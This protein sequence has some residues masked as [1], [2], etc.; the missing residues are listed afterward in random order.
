MVGNSLYDVEC[1]I[2]LTPFDLAYIAVCELNR[3]RQ[4]LQRHPAFPPN[5]PHVHSEGLRQRHAR[6]R[7]DSFTSGQSL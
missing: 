5:A 1:G 4:R 7:N 2:S 6:K 3:V